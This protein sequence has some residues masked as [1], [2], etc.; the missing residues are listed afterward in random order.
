MLPTSTAP[1]VSS[2]TLHAPPVSPPSTACGPSTELTLCVSCERSPASPANCR[3]PVRS[4]RPVLRT[5]DR[6]LSAI[7]SDFNS[8]ALSNSTNHYV[9]NTTPRTSTPPLPPGSSPGTAAATSPSAPPPRDQVVPS[10][11]A[12]S[13]S[14]RAHPFAPPTQ[15]KAV[16]LPVAAPLSPHAHPF[17]TPR[18]STPPL[19]PGSSHGT[20][21]AAS[22]SAPPPRDQVVPLSVACSLSPHAHPFAPPTQGLALPSPVATP[23]SPHAHPFSIVLR[24]LIRPAE[25]PYA[26]PSRLPLRPRLSPTPPDAVHC[27]TAGSPPPSS[28]TAQCAPPRAVPCS[29]TASTP[30]PLAPR[31]TPASCV[32]P[33][34][35][36]SRPLLRPR[37]CTPPRTIPSLAPSL[38]CTPA[39]SVHSVPLRSCC[40]RPL[41][42]AVRCPRSLCVSWAQPLVC[43]THTVPRR[44]SSR[45]AP[46]RATRR[47]WPPGVLAGNQ[48]DRYPRL[49]RL[50][51]PRPHTN[52]ATPLP[53]P[54]VADP[55]TASVATRPTGSVRAP[56]AAT[57]CAPPTT[58]TGCPPPGAP[59]PRTLPAAS[60]PLPPSPPPATSTGRRVHTAK[61]RRSPPPAGGATAVASAPSGAPLSA[62]A[63]TLGPYTPAH[64]P[65]QGVGEQVRFAVH[66]AKTGMIMQYVKHRTTR[67]GVTCTVDYTEAWPVKRGVPVPRD[68]LFLVPFGFHPS[69]GSIEVDAVLYFLPGKTEQIRRVAG[70]L[71]GSVPEAGS[72][73]SRP[74]P[75]PLDARP[76]GTCFHRRWS[77]TWSASCSAKSFAPTYTNSTRAVPGDALGLFDPPPARHLR[78]RRTHRRHAR[79]RHRAPALCCRRRP[80]RPRRTSPAL[81]RRQS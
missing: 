31:A 35:G 50:R 48:H 80:H 38:P 39:G 75:P 20:A 8:G 78:L 30:P 44:C 57:A 22:P 27:A 5:S 49:P 40:R 10:P 25:P 53:T 66:G 54:T 67:E 3:P 23:L 32:P 41:C 33:Y 11:V 21:A 15:G 61:R 59:P 70:L 46:Q 17:T 79:T 58:P 45:P 24:A 81:R 77:A 1:A 74:G 19:P 36:L 63:I 64:Q 76:M 28:A 62:P 7:A 4:V 2:S 9:T 34:P 26:T 69:S 13:L 56:P 42:G 55:P 51:K 43:G 16:P 71:Y 52:T 47:A 12:C 65:I 37:L 14:P 73:R 6:V 29:A 18:T 60:P 72:L 68:D